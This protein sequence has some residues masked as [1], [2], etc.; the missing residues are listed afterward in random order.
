[1]KRRIPLRRLAPVLL[2]LFQAASASVAA[3]G[4]PGANEEADDPIVARGRDLT[5]RASELEATLVRRFAVTSQGR[6]ILKL[7]LN[8]RVLEELGQAR[9]LAV[10]AKEVDALFRRL[11]LQARASGSPQG[12]LGELAQKQLTLEEFRE[13]LRLS[14]LQERLA[15][16]ALGIPEDRPVSGD[17]QEVWLQQQMIERGLDWP[18][19]PWPNG[20]VARCGDV[21][22]RERE[23][24]RELRKRLPGDEVRESAWHVLLLRGIEQRMPDLSAEARGRALDA[25]MDRRRAK[26]GAAG[27]QGVSFEEIVGSRGTTIA[28]LRA[29]P[30]VQIAALSWLWVDRTSGPE[31]LRATY[32]AERA[33]FEGLY[34]RAVRA[35]LHFLKAAKYENELTPRTFED[36][37]A[38]LRRLGAKLGGV[39]DFVAWT[40]EH[41]EDPTSRDNGGDLGW[42]TRKDARV[43]SAVPEAIFGFLDGGGT[44]PPG[45]RALPPVRLESGSA[46]LWVS[47]VRES[48]A[49]EE[50][51]AHVH[52]ELRRRFLRDVLP[53][54]ELELLTP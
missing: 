52:E 47:D 2:V 31:G 16:E 24:G 33:L 26:V 4:A 12:L 42:V 39:E 20:I 29:D 41:S 7:L 43:P 35:H 3:P 40:Q 46:L 8:S 38:Q 27:V 51:S 15:R 34:G 14:I 28:A 30:S 36:A 54:Q 10:G 1:M 21:V 19:P 53:P 13:Y 17:Q 18:P 50:M 49:W 45:G 9:G 6:D 37:E 23:L 44:I 5:L 32:E 25:E 48:P 11:D 22:V